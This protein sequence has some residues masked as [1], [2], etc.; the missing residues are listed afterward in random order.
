MS[1]QGMIKKQDKR[2]QT[3]ARAIKPQVWIGK[4]GLTDEIIRQ[5]NL[6]LKKRKLVKIKLL[7]SFLEK[8]DK[9]QAAK[10]LAKLTESEIVYATGFVVVLYKR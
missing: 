5:V 10:K 3:Q 4:N 8:T 2:I 6:L 1:I 7:E 9:K